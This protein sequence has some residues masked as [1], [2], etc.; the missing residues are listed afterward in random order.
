MNASEAYARLV[1]LGVPV[2]RTAEAAAALRVTPKAA[3][4]ALG[5]LA[6]A[7]LLS[8]IRSGVWL[9]GSASIDR[10]AIVEAL[11]APLPSYVSLQTALYL[12]GMIEQV[13]TVVYA[14]T[15]GETERV[16]TSIA[17]YSFHHIAP[18]LFDGFDVRPDSTKIATP[19]KALFDMA[20]FSGGRTRLFARLPELE[21][22]KRLREKRLRDWT[23]RISAPRRRSMVTTR[24]ARMLA[25]ADRT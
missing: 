6:N 18:E 14:V 22:P 21:L 12:H 20:Y 25:G 15:L 17:V 3:S 10:Y 8:R 13:P 5:R 23:A 24:L 11:T 1:Q 9:V 16:E 19:E 4:M 2:I 7:G